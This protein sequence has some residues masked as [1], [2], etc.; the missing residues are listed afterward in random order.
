[1]PESDPGR[2]AKV[3]EVVTMRLRPGSAKS[4]TFVTI[5]DETGQANLVI[6]P[7]V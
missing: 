1:L 7:D 5:E 6:R 4:I 3:A 2:R